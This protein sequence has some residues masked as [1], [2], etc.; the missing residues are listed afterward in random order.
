MGG[1]GSISGMSSGGA[2][3][4]ATIQM[5]TQ[6]PN[7]VPTNQ[8]AQQANNTTF[9][10]TDTADYH[11]LFGG[12]QYFQSQNLGIDAR[13]AVINYL[14]D[15][16]EPGSLYSMSQNMNTAMANGTS[17]TANQ[18]YTR[19][20]LMAA[21]HNLGYN[22]NLQRYDHAPFI[23]KLLSD[24]GVKNADYTKL[25]AAQLKSALVGHTY[26]EN[27]FLSTSYNDFKNAGA[28]NPFTN[29]A[30]RIEYKAKAGTQAMMPGNGPGGQLGEI[31][32]A[33]GQS[34]KIVDVKYSGK[35]A[36]AKGSQSLSLPQVTLV[37]EIG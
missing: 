8:Q 1:R 27:K 9:A 19:N 5:Q 28:N 4:G 34:T 14:S 37:V 31:I 13:M 32:L 29:R 33:P 18:Q 2:G 36:R 30:V 26:G 16:P 11:D 23:N 25:S 35:K 17:L 15:Q 20:N 6:P 21:M 22:L 3:G 7:I 10:A 24:V 12:R